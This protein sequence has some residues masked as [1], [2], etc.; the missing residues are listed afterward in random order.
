MKGHIEFVVR[1]YTKEYSITSTDNVYEIKRRLLGSSCTSLDQYYV[2]DQR[3]DIAL[4]DDIPSHKLKE[5]GIEEPFTFYLSKNIPVKIMDASGRIMEKSRLPLRRSPAQRHAELCEENLLEDIVRIMKQRAM[6]GNHTPYEK[7]IKHDALRK[8]IC[9][10]L[11][12]DGY[13]AKQSERN[14]GVTK[15]EFPFFNY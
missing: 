13:I 9:E 3:T 15:I 2:Y 1:H 11:T 8:S 5:F 12:A 6:D 7:E 10:S 4:H 14:P